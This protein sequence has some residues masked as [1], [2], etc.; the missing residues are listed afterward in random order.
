MI[1]KELLYDRGAINIFGYDNKKNFNKINSIIGYCPQENIIFENMKVKEI[2][3]FFN[4]LKTNKQTAIK[5]CTIFG[6]NKYLNTYCSNLSWGN[7]R[8][9][10]LAI[11]LMNKPNLLLL[12]EPSTGMD[13]ISKKIMLNI[14]YS[15]IKD[16]QRY[17]IIF[18][19]NS[20][21]EAGL[22]CDRISYFKN[23]NYSYLGNKDK[24]IEW[25]SYGLNPDSG[26]RW[27]W[28]REQMAARVCGLPRHAISIG[29]ST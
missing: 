11:A 4:E 21:E 1:T 27:D 10:A 9:L 6:L 25:A 13:P 2:I 19:T 26:S 3:K 14:I 29:I 12:D 15:S 20:I 22:L 17:N 5:I 7:K 28:L 16:N 18:S 23:G 24:I 8:K